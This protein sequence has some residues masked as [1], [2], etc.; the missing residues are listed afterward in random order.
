MIE[1]EETKTV[2]PDKAGAS[3]NGD[4][5]VVSTVDAFEESAEPRVVY[6]R[7]EPIETNADAP[8]PVSA[9]R[10]GRLGQLSPAIVPLIVGFL[11]LLILIAVLGLLSVSRM[12]Q[13]GHDVLNLEQAHLAK[14]S[15]LLKLRLA[16]TKLDNEARTRAEADARRELKPPFDFRLSKARGEV[17]ALLDQL[18][19]PPLSNDPTWV[20][21][22]SD[23]ATYVDVTED[24]RRY[25]LEG[26]QKFKAVDTKLNTLLA[27]STQEQD[28][29]SRQGEIIEQNAARSIR[30]WSVIALLVGALVAAG[31]IWEVQRRFGEMRR[32]VEE[33]RRE[34]NFTSQLL[35]GMVSAVA[36]IDENDRIRSA[37]AAFFRI[38]PRATIGASVYEKFAPEAALK[39]L[40]AA[41]ATLVNQASYRGR[42]LCPAAENSDQQQTFDVYSSPLAINGSRGQILTLVDVTEAAEAERG[43]RRQ[44][45]LA[46]VGQATAQVAHE[47]RNPLGSIRLGVSMLRDSV[48][49]DEGLNTIELVE[50]GIKHLNKLVVDV[51][52]FSRRKTLEQT[53]VDLHELIKRSLEL[54]TDKIKDKET[55]IEK[56][57][58]GQKLIGHWDPDQL[59]QVFVNIIANAIDASSKRAPIVISTSV[60]N[61]AGDD[62]DVPGKKLAR[63]TIADQGQGMDKTTLDRI[64]EPFFSTKKR[65]TGLGLAIVKQIVE[66]HDGTISVSSESGKGTRFVIDLPL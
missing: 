44:E 23:L 38:F 36:A 14:L 15:Y 64:F 1:K 8:G 51:A 4:E 18:E 39:M 2:E 21:F 60:V 29:I 5:P 53:N 63:V 25:S 35:E 46:A 61:I 27:Q 65:G 12:D 57:L 40:E 13:V 20:S 55:P 62:E 19:H 30:T 33:A 9:P 28:E 66:Q 52:Q 48:T 47:I 32:S 26:F 56:K 24:L 6:R 42:W 45:S 58:A 41:T 37:N 49:D 17:N 43:S 50:R 16:V 31:T 22:R 10:A 11:V 54:V 3:G 7:V 59:S 34:R